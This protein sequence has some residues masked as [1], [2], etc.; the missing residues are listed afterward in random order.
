MTALYL[1]TVTHTRYERARRTFRYGTFLWLVDL[2]DLPRLPRALA[3][4]RA[5]DHFAGD[6]ATIRDGLASWLAEKGMALGGGRVLM[7]SGAAVLGY[8]FNPLT[9]FWCHD[10]DGAPLCVV[11]EVHN[12]YGGRHAYVLHPDEQD[13]ATTAKELYVSPFFP[14]DGR[15]AMSVPRPGHR[16]RL[17]VTLFRPGPG[18]ADVPAFAASLTGRRRPATV[19]QLLRLLLRYPWAPLRVSALIRWQ[20]VRLWLRRLPVVPRRGAAA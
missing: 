1:A 2:D 4:F 10:A 16:L 18:G 15:Y 5:R 13:R 9:V 12:T 19:P 20:G 17:A 3:A 8:V 14:V 7:L 6:A 11:A